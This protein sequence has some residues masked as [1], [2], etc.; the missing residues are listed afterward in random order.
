MIAFPARTKRLAFLVLVSAIA[1]CGSESAPSARND[2]T[3]AG[4]V[5]PSVGGEARGAGDVAPVHGAS[6]WGVYVVVAAAA[7]PELETAA[8]PLRQRGIRVSVGEVGCDAGAS[9]ALSAT[10]DAHAVSV[11]FATR[12]DA[13]R[14][15]ATLSTPPAGIAQVTVGCAD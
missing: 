4:S 9:E 11:M 3:R 13:D 15:A 14:F 7:A 5:S 2:T 12:A 6:L 10:P 1:A 8:E